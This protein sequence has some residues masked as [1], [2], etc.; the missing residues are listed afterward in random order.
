V[1][2]SVAVPA[3]SQLAPAI[4]APS[5]GS[6]TSQAVVLSSGGVAVT[7]A[8]HG[9][10]GWSEAPCVSRTA[11]DW[12]FASGNTS[13][14]NG[15][16]ISVFNPTSS[17]VVVDLSFT[18]ASG[19][20]HP[21][22]FQG[23]VLDPGQVQVANVAAYVQE[24]STVATTVSSR[25]GRVV[26]SELE[27]FAA[28]TGGLSVIPGVPFVASQWSIPQSDEVTG[29][30]SEIDV[31]NP[32]PGTENVT[33]NLRLASGPLAPLQHAV[34][35][36][37]TWVLSTTSQTR[38]PKGD[39]YSAEISAR[40]AGG[41][42]VGRLV[43]ASSLAQAPQAGVANAIDGLTSTWPSHQW[44]VPSP[45]STATPAYSGALPEHLALANPTGS[46]EH[47]VVLVMTPDGTRT[48]L[49][50]SVRAHQ[51]TMIGGS[52]LFGAGL[53]SLIVRASGPLSVSE[54]VGL[55][56]AFGVITMPGIALD[57]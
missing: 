40:G 5:S 2:T 56:G 54:D 21:I 3:R 46:A 23:M 14:T 41:V 50:G 42:V 34:P 29:G 13:G 22:N 55:S 6:W 26:A 53:Y 47:F 4:A 31:F 37:S 20:V 45:G 44:L 11:Q 57:S 24:Q 39:P 8:V 52:T 19:V 27:Q 35:A 30:A 18:T 38:I 28:P 25:T 32:G 1:Q 51:G 10:S 48:I 33:V 15:L 36:L 17:P 16:Y 7:Q 49:S 12:Y 9:A 43:V